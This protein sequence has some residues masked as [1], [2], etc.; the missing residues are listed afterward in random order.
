ME[1]SSLAGSSIESVEDLVQLVEKLGAAM[2]PT[3]E[4]ILH[5]FANMSATVVAVSG[6]VTGR[7][8][9][10]PPTD[11]L[12]SHV[13]SGADRDLYYYRTMLPDGRELS[14][15]TIVLRSAEGRPLGAICVNND[16]SLWR[17]VADLAAMATQRERRVEFTDST[18]EQIENSSADPLSRLG[19]L[20]RR[21]SASSTSEGLATS[22]LDS[23]AIPLSDDEVRRGTPPGSGHEVQESFPHSIGELANTMV[24]QSIQSVGIPI[25][26]MRKKHKMAIVADLQTRGIFQLRES[27]DEIAAALHVS[28]FTIYKYLNEI[29]A[30][31]GNVPADLDTG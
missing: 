27:V 14:S 6:S 7:R 21:R 22:R 4:I 16:L 31:G 1:L 18:S 20:V 9:G 26:D 3:T 2:P 29:E 10:D 13:A 15:S 5:D 30:L 24:A 23:E 28:R 17:S 25:T 8:V 19:A 12:L 11:L